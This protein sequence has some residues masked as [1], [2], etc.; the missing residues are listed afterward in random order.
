MVKIKFM[1][2]FRI[3]L[4]TFLWGAFLGVMIIKVYWTGYQEITWLR[5]Y[6]VPY[7]WYETP[8]PKIIDL[9]LVLFA[10]L[11][12]GFLFKDV[13]SLFYCYIT[14]I[15]IS[16]VLSFMFVIWYM[17]NVL[18]VEYLFSWS[19]FNWEWGVFIAGLNVLK[20]FF[21]QVFFVSLLGTVLGILLRGLFF[22]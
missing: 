4:V 8:T 13:K 2:N 3:L 9:F 21:P 16:F 6:S 15:L 22:Y 18:R 17:Q 10:S 7:G 1:L 12:A 5:Y 11:G 19:S 14:A 20:I